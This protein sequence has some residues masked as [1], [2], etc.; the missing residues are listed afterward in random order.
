MPIM[1]INLS[2]VLVAFF[3]GLA[4]LVPVVGLTAR[5]ALRPVVDAMAR[6]KEAGNSR[7]ALTMLERRMSLLEQ[8]V[9]G[10][11]GLRQEV[12]RLA[13]AERFHLKLVGRGEEARAE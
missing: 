12:A 3:C 2:E 9:Q 11:E 13:D 7:D 10:I 4:V 1:P 5:F 8:E 6:M